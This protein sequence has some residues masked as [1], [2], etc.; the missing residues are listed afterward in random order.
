M[1][2]DP[3][4]PVY[5]S[6]RIGRDPREVR[7]SPRQD[8]V[9]YTT[10]STERQIFFHFWASQLLGFNSLPPCRRI[11]THRDREV[12]PTGKAFVSPSL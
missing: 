11:R 4:A 1:E 5:P 2:G 8:Y 7:L 9:N 10:F 6:H 12:S 3:P